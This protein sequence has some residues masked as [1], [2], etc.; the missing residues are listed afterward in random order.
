MSDEH[1]FRKRFS[2]MSQEERERLASACE[3]SV[4]HLRNVAFSGKPCGYPLAVRLEKT[5]GI[6]RWKSRPTDWHEVWP[7]LIDT[8][9]APPI[10]A[11]TASLNQA[12]QPATTTEAGH[13]A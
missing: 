11:S 8:E 1:D 7:D 9:G 4:G 13:A 10:P 3:T 6:P 5:L 12:A 2:A